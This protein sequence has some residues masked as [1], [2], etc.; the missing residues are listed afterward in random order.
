MAGFS[1][2]VTVVIDVV[3][4]K[5]KTGIAGFKKS[6]SE[7]E[8]FTG[9]L[10]AGWGSLSD[11]LSNPAAM[12]TA[13][14][15][16]VGL[17]AHVLEAGQALEAMDAKAEAVF[18]DR[19]GDVR[20]WSSENAAALG[21][22]T[23]EATD[24]AAA[25]A[26]LLKPMG[27]TTAEATK[28][29][30]GL[31]DL[32]GALSAWSGGQR[33]AADVSD[34]LVKAMLGEREQLKSLGI[35]ITEAE[36]QSRLAAKG[37]DKLKGAALA[38]AKALVTQTLIV[39]KSTDAQK[40]WNSGAQDGQKKANA[41]RA[42]Y[43][44]LEET[45]VRDLYPAVLQLAA[46][47]A[48]ATKNITPLIDKIGQF[49]GAVD[50]L[51]DWLTQG[52][53]AV[54]WGSLFGNDD[55]DKAIAKLNK[56][57]TAAS[58]SIDE[59]NDARRRG[60]GVTKHY[61]EVTDDSAESLDRVKDASWKAKQALDGLN[62]IQLDAIDSELAAFR[63]GLDWTE[64]QQELNK[65]LKDSQAT[66][67]DKTNAVLDYAEAT[68][69]AAAAQDK[70][71][72]GEQTADEKKRILLDTI[73]RLA[74]GLDPNSPLRKNLDAY[75]AALYSIPTVV[76]PKLN[77]PFSGQSAPDGRGRGP[78]GARVVNNITIQTKADPNEVIAIIR[79]YTRQN[80]RGWM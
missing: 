57:N 50:R 42:A 5:A 10:K 20:A 51:P 16:A 46:G 58:F 76:G 9:K 31:M 39:E 65:T 19:L 64:A 75:I 14:T 79:R 24:A 45:V 35:S 25:I 22:T 2:K 43:K 71:N 59:V 73:S 44:Q 36:V 70:A 28:Q 78:D 68:A 63:A 48:Q 33:S 41:Q 53:F 12:A 3:T 1:D 60:T 7:A 11:T 21:L 80:G 18:V 77:D 8:G 56:L 32:A 26:D 37:Q 52:A 38:Q 4:E 62:D 54:D 29:T 6:V 27:F 55:L 34:I 67:E 47:L 30:L 17:A 49:G 40:A 61:V 66:V 74:S 69:A 23:S 13:G 72:G 15:A